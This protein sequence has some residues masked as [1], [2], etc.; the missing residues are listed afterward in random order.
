MQTELDAQTLDPDPFINGSFS[1]QVQQDHV[2][3]V[4]AGPFQQQLLLSSSMIGVS[5]NKEWF[6]YLE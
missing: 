2:L 1:A 6:V 5:V 4:M 3:N